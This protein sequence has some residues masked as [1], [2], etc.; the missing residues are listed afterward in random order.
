MVADVL[1]EEGKAVAE[2]IRQSGST[3]GFVKLDITDEE[4]WKSAIGAT[5]D[6]LG[7]MDI[8]V[9][10]AGVLTAAL[11]VDVD[12]ADV[13]SMNDINILGTL[14]GLK[15]GLRAMRPEGLA[16]NG[17]SIVNLSSGAATI[18]L[19]SIAVYSATK[20]AI[21]RL[22]RVAAVESG[23]LGYGVRVNCVY[24]GFVSTTMGFGLAEDMARLGL[25][26]SQQAALDDVIAS[27]PL[28][29]LADVSD[30]ADAVLFLASDAARY[31]TGIGLPVDGGMGT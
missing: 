2:T 8:L 18:A 28:G 17:G 6:E 1:E 15:Q 11:I 12:P 27:T 25:A 21:D 20:S 14:L 23:K 10:N 16:G 31:V 3:A 24:P 13:R 30:I 19:P 26:T 29:R 22:T 5:I 9:N 7:G 4:Q